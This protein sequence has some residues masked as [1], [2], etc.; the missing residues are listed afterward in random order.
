MIEFVEIVRWLTRSVA[1]SFVSWPVGRERVNREQVA[2]KLPGCEWAEFE[3][4]HRRRRRNQV[5]ASWVSSLPKDSARLSRGSG[6]ARTPFADYCGR[7]PA[8]VE[9]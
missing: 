6:A 8:R 5:S 9:C 2:I 3:L 4:A 1:C 7:Q